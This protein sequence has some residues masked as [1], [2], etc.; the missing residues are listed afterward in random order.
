MFQTKLRFTGPVT[1][2]IAERIW[3]PAQS[4]TWESDDVL[5][6][7]MPANSLSEMKKFVLSYGANVEALEP[8]KLREKVREEVEEMRRLYDQ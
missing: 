3:H 4:I 1:R 2:Y 7:E 5:L 8:E 6:L